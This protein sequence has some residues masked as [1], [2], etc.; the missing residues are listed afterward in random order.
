MRTYTNVKVKDRMGILQHKGNS[1]HWEQENGVLK[2][3]KLNR[4][5]RFQLCTGKD[6]RHERNVRIVF[7]N[8][9]D[10]EEGKAETVTFQFMCK[11]QQK[12][13]AKDLRKVKAKNKGPLGARMRK[14]FRGWK[15]SEKAGGGE[16]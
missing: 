2:T 3:Y 9:T 16:Q 15:G 7:A 14:W 11:K 8:A 6:W 4:L 12:G 5:Q 10:P 1:L 13:L